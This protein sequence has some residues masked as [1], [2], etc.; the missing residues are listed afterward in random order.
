MLK[1]Y[2][3]FAL[4]VLLSNIA[5]A[6]QFI[7]LNATNYP[8]I[9][10]MPYNPAWVN[11]S[12]SGTE[13]HVFSFSALAGTNAFRFDKSY[14]LGAGSGHAKENVDYER[15][16]TRKVKHMWANADILGPAISFTYKKE[17]H[18]GIY[19]RMREIVRGGNI[20]SSELQL[21]SDTPRNDKMTYP[22]LEFNHAG[23]STQTF[24]EIG[25]TYGQVLM[26]DEFRIMRAG[27]TLK[28]LLGFNAASL[29]TDHLAYQRKNKDTLGTITGDIT[30]LYT[31]NADP[32]LK[33]NI[34]N[35]L[36][37]WLDR[38]GRGGLGLDLG[39]Q[40]EYHPTGNPNEETPYQYSIAVSITDIGSVKYIADTGS[41]KYT[42]QLNAKANNV[43]GR[44]DNETIGDYF[45]RLSKDSILSKGEQ[46]RSFR[47]GLPTALRANLDYNVVP[48]FSM[49]V[50]ILL[51]LKGNNGKVYN[52]G[53]V[54]YFNITPTYGGKYVKVS[55]PFTY[56]G[57][58]TMA[59]GA[60]V[61]LGPFYIGSTSA[62]SSLVLAKH[63]R[64]LDAFAGLTF[65]FKKERIFY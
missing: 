38:G 51:N 55:M 10:Q 34:G 61:H 46:V 21:I 22:Q 64:N 19:T 23:F 13:F 65:K 18:I 14:L 1:K 57:Y 7:G 35:Q 58:Q 12:E 42:A 15:N 62:I 29:Y 41:A 32:Y 39:F 44:G 60:I 9:Q 53:Y 8:T 20:A 52:P 50:N 43:L 49:A 16:W 59:I 28:Y 6:Q 30:A 25:I 26:N 5:A 40:Y 63:I 54:S 31:Y 37:S 3:S 24:G 56:V 33:G 17:H 48:N 11:T 2:F 4:I 27:V 47:M 36:S 45:I